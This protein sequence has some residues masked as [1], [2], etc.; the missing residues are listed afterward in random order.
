M[1]E[2]KCYL[3]LSISTSDT[4]DMILI[5]L[6]LWEEEETKGIMGTFS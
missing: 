4:S 2:I 6:T 3:S 1:D 5:E